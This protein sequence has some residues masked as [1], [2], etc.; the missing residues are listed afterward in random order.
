MHYI[1]VR[2]LSYLVNEDTMYIT[3]QDILQQE[4]LQ[5]TKHK[6]RTIL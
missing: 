2:F 4:I 5:H 6:P 1:V 3:N